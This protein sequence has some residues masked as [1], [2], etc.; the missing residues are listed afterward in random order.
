MASKG[1][2]E[3]NAVQQRGLNKQLHSLTLVFPYF[4]VPISDRANTELSPAVTV[5]LLAHPYPSMKPVPSK[6][7]IFFR[8]VWLDT[9]R[10]LEDDLYQV[11]HN[12]LPA[13]Y[14]GF[15][16]YNFMPTGTHE[17]PNEQYYIDH[18]GLH[19]EKLKLAKIGV[20]EELIKADHQT[21]ALV[22]YNPVD[23]QQYLVGWYKKA[24]IYMKTQETEDLDGNVI[25]YQATAPIDKSSRLLPI[26][27]RTFRIRHGEGSDMWHSGSISARDLLD[28]WGY[29]K[30]FP[31]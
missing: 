30:Q 3:A 8:V 11:I 10:G 13:D 26:K 22:S 20:Q 14:P 28:F 12:S 9:Y 15:D 23:E 31:G 19:Y 17:Q 1:F 16:V 2:C 24:T 5:A 27:N 4:T 21:I 18:F 6:P 7:I 25:Q 29:V